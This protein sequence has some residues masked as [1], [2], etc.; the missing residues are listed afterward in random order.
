MLPDLLEPG[1]KLVVCGTAAGTRS[2]M[3]QQ[4]YAGQG[5]KFWGTLYDVGLTRELLSPRRYPLLLKY[6]IGLTDLSK[7]RSGMDSDL[8]RHDFDSLSLFEKIKK[9]EP[10]YFCFNGKKAAEEFFH[11]D[12]IYGIQPERIE[13]S[14]TRFFVAPSTSSAAN[15]YWDIEYWEGLARLCRK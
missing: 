11:R 15:R 12:V 8:R 4:Y 6:K 14:V 9:Y 5:N 1:L 10:K 13:N 2:A 7:T 3:L